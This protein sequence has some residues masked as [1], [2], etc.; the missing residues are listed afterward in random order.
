MYSDVIPIEKSALLFVIGIIMRL[1]L[2]RGCAAKLSQKFVPRT[3]SGIQPTGT[4][5]LG[6][7][8]GAVQQWVKDIKSSKEDRNQRIF[9]VVD[10]HAITLPQDSKALHENIMTMA[11]SLIGSG[12]DP[13]KSILFQQSTVP[14]HTE[15]AWILGCQCTV[16]ALNRMSQYKDKTSGMKEAPVGLFMYPVLQAADI[17]LYKATRVPVGED[18]LQ[19]VEMTRTLARLFCNKFKSKVFPTPSALLVEEDAGRRVRSLRK[20]EKKMSKSDSDAKS[21]VYI[22]DEPDVM[23]SKIKKAVTDSTS[24]MTFDLANRP[25]V[26]NLI[27]IYSCLSGQTPAEVC[28]SF[29]SCDTGQFKLH[30][31]DLMIEYFTPIRQEINYLLDNRDHLEQVLRK[32]TD[33]AAEIAADTMVEVRKAVG[34]T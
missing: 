23:R 7:Y 5:H 25:G 11:A 12:I 13:D 19:N 14:S 4:L 6:N 31:A 30:L 21:C 9:S 17:L 10:L 16:P 18:N 20:P 8:F 28:Q 26:S 24:A 34:F 22:T 15:L 2:T 33:S 32:G 29:S 1:T 27:V 3:F